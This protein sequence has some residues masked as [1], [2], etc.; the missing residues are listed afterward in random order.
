MKNMGVLINCMSFHVSYSGG[1]MSISKQKFGK[2][3]GNDIYEYII[4]HKNLELH[5]LNYGGII[6]SLFYKGTDV[7]LGYDSIEEYADDEN[8]FGALIGRNA[9]RIGNAEFVLNGKLYKLNKNDGNNNL[10]GG[11]C[12]FNKKVWDV[13]D[14][15]ENKI[16][17][18]LISN[19]GD[20]GF[21]GEVNVRVTYT[22]TDSDA[23]N[24]RYE[25]QT[26]KD[27]ILNMTNHSY[28]NLNGHDQGSIENHILK[29]NSLFYTPND[30]ECKPTGEILSVK[31]TPLDF[32]LDKK[33]EEAFRN[34]FVQTSMFGGIDHNF[35]IEGRGMRT[36]AICSGD[37]TGI[38]M[39]VITDCAGIQI[40]ADN[41]LGNERIGKNSTLYP[42]HSGVCFET[43]AFPGSVEYAHFTNTI[44]RH[45][46]KYETETE[47]KFSS[48]NNTRKK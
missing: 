20:E 41:D 38:S 37:K 11:F 9:N 33:I 36:A 39:E 40:Y 18:T 13:E 19:D 45:E 6:R 2:I 15:Y 31:S 8:Y 30:A 24:I 34:D 47:Y 7:V 27:T 29:L 42:E 5:V 25:G 21:P 22:L 10:H 14:A 26:D 44:L 35:V 1:N 43:Q 3:D 28:F 23:L 48:T 16:V 46:E 17:F 4:C 12:G 32:T